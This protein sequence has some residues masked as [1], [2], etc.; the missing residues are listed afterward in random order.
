M[1][2]DVVEVQQS[3]NVLHRL[4]IIQRRVAMIYSG[5]RDPL[6]R[7]Y[8]NAF[9]SLNLDD[10]DPENV[11]PDDVAMSLA[12]HEE[13]VQRLR[14]KLNEQQGEI[15]RKIGHFTEIIVAGA[16]RAFDDR[17]VD[18]ATYF[19]IPG[20]VQLS[21]CE[22]ILRREGIIQAD[23][24]HEID[25]MGLY[26][27]YGYRGEHL[28]Y[29]D[30]RRYGAWMISVRYRRKRMGVAAVRQF[31]RDAEAVQ[32]EK[33]YSEVKYWYFSKSG[34]TKDAKALLQARGIYYSDLV[35]FNQLAEMFDLMQLSL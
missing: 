6:M 16:V 28:A 18:G 15:N 20:D 10:L 9:H 32:E 14:R 26:P 27:F 29:D 25:F 4:D 33:G 8:L 19:G 17:M 30:N 22:K 35:Q 24:V 31:I 3:I 23:I 11:V 5:P 7:L 34:F 2:L 21:R 13:S 12:G 1:N